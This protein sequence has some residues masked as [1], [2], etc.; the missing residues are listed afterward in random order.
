MKSLMINR[1]DAPK[2]HLEAVSTGHHEYKVVHGG[3]IDDEH[4]RSPIGYE[5]WIQ[6]WESN[7]SVRLENIGDT[8]V[9][10]PWLSNG[11]NNI[12]TVN[13]IL[14]TI[15]E[16]GMT[17]REKAISIWRWSTKHRFHGNTFDREFHDPVKVFNVYGYNACGEDPVVLGCLWRT[18]GLR[19]RS[20]RP[21]SHLAYEVFFDGQ[22]HLMDGDQNAFY[23]LRDNSTIADES[24]VARDHDL[25]KRTH[26]YG[27]LR[28]DDREMDEFAASLWFQEEPGPPVG[29]CMK[30]HTMDMVLRPGEAIVWRWGNHEVNKFHGKLPNLGNI[31]NGVWEYRM[32]LTA[33]GWSKGAHTVRDVEMGPNGIKSSPDKVGTV[34]WKMGMPYVLLGGRLGIKGK[35]IQLSLSW[36]GDEWF[37][38]GENFDVMF[39]QYGPPRYHYYL[40]C[41]LPGSASLEHLSIFNTIQIAPLSLP[42]VHVGPND[43][44]YTDETTAERKV[45]I[46]HEWVE[47]SFTNPPLSPPA[48]IYPRDG[49]TVEGTKISFAWD[50]PQ[51]PDGDS[52]VDYHF[53]LSDRPDMK[54]PLSPNF[55]K[56]ISNTPQ[57]GK[58]R[59]EVPYP[60]LLNSDAQYYWRVRAKD[61]NGAWGPWS[62][63]WSFT[64]KGPGPP[65][66]VRIEFIPS[67]NIGILKWNPGNTGRKPVKYRVYGSN[68]KGFSVSDA[69]YPVLVGEWWQLI[70]PSE[71]RNPFPANF[72]TETT[73]M[74][75]PVI[76]PG[77]VLKNANKAFYRI[78]AVDE[79][80]N[81]SGPSD[82]AAVQRPFIYTDPVL[83]VKKNRTFSHQLRTIYSI[84]DLHCRY[85]E[86]SG[87]GYNANFWSVDR[88]A[89]SLEQYPPFLAL[90]GV[91]LLSGTPRSAGDFEVVVSTSISTLPKVVQQF[92]IRV[93]D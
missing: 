62:A 13:E 11:K 66:D 78:V 93:V 45:K 65:T 50:A 16:P 61:Q 56:L 23:L 41:Q 26:N 47:T 19:V 2:T 85:Y 20:A 28:R 73:H 90:T 71:L 86:W 38:I 30:T 72:I 36:D 7:R 44:V 92:I 53:E 87:I 76:G 32:N 51:D 18:A 49:S 37:P 60:G 42:G 79:F 8:N 88:P 5:P 27:I 70:S 46:T 1:S 52:I 4:C 24:Q 91:G 10:N 40:R 67:R 83:I 34:I 25:V 55:D 59:Y 17:D 9:I 48:P 58:T 84:G 14:R 68:E 12:R 21:F 39:P 75:L 22:W 74:E 69:A 54:W 31:Y 33:S 82:H 80:G 43:F 35:G 29:D 77:L 6:S 89:F 57:R 63:I 3:A 64:P 81:Q 15:L